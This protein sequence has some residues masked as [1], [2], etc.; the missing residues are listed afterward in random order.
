[1]LR[2]RCV[3]VRDWNE[4][5]IMDLSQRLQGKLKPDLVEAIAATTV[6]KLVIDSG[7]TKIMLKGDSKVV[8]DALKCGTSNLSIVSTFTDQLRSTANGFE[9]YAISWTR[10]EKKTK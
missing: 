8:I 2:D 9:E 6:T 3:V 4:S 5:F 1:C 7:Y 10:G